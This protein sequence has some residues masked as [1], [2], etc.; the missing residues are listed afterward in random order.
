MPLKTSHSNAGAAEQTQNELPRFFARQP[1]LDLREQNFG[2]EFLFRSGTENYCPSVTVAEL[3]VATQLMLDNSILYDFESLVGSGKIFLNCTRDALTSGLLTLLPVRSTV[4]EILEDV[5]P[6]NEVLQACRSLRELGFQLSLDD[7][8]PRPG[9]E[10]FLPYADFIKIDFR[11]SDATERAKTRAFLKNCDARL[12]AEKIERQEEFR[13]AVE[14]GFDLFQ[15]YFFCY[16]AMLARNRIASNPLAYVEILAALSQ[17]SFDW[18]TIERLVRR[19]TSLCY[20]LL[21]LVNSANYGQRYEITSIE[22]ALI[23]VG[24]EDFSK[25]V[26]V[27]ITAESGKRHPSELIRQTLQ[28]AGFC[29]MAATYLHQDPTE[30]Y[31]FGL[32]SLLPVLL[33]VP[34]SQV[35]SLLPLRAPVKAA[36]MGEPNEISCPL[37]C[38]LKYQAGEWDPIRDDGPLLRAGQMHELYRRSLIWADHQTAA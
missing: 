23:I 15:G 4:L 6:D 10:K 29:E 30:Q 35:V 36:L 17:K 5:E 3:N 18:R 20:R 8:V 32:I 9:L 33:G 12:I 26:T 27:A 19:E 34:M 24:E 14:E 11:L 21:R 1:I 2:Y 13:V 16:P 22:K 31:L 37:N 38:L 28:R 25:L 7:F